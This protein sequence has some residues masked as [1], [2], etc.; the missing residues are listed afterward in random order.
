LLQ[1]ADFVEFLRLAAL[2]RQHPETHQAAFERNTDRAQLLLFV[3][4]GAHPE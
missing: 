4:V 1:V 3:V 2:N